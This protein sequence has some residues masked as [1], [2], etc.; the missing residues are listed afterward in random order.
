MLELRKTLELAYLEWTNDFLTMEKFAEY[1]GISKEHA[2][3]LIKI[4]KE[5]HEERV[6]LLNGK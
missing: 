4:G 1:H 2:M 5:I 6:E 3:T